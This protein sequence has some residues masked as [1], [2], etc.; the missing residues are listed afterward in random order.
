M[1]RIF[2]E[3]ENAVVN[4]MEAPFRQRGIVMDGTPQGLQNGKAIGAPFH[5]NPGLAVTY[6]AILAETN[7]LVEQDK[8]HYVNKEAE[9]FNKLLITLGPED[10]T[11]LQ[12]FLSKKPLMPLDG[13]REGFVNFI[14]LAEWAKQRGGINGA[15]LEAAMRAMTP[16]LRDG[17]S[18]LHWK[19]PTEV[20]FEERQF[21]AGRRNHAADKQETQKQEPQIEYSKSG[22]LNHASDKRYQQEQKP[23]TPKLDA[24]EQTWRNMAE[25]MLGSGSVHSRN[26]ELQETFDAAVQ[27]GRSWRSVYDSVAK[28]K[29]RQEALR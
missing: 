13:S 16:G 23:A 3:E 8:L 29:K 25:Q 15:N 18:P 6:D 14:K 17:V 10:V 12:N 1:A 24:S 28:V 21:V 19:A 26:S 5:A 4:Q 27:E 20:P 11:T 22:K 7:K 9:Q 2:T